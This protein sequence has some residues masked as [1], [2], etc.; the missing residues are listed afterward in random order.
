MFHGPCVADCKLSLTV[1]N[2]SSISY[3]ILLFAIINSSLKKLDN[4]RLQVL[5]NHQTNSTINNDLVRGTN[6]VA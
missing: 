5:F 1:I 3:V 4:K 6:S 2:F